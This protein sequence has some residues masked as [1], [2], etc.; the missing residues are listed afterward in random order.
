MASVECQEKAINNVSMG[1]PGR[2]ELR[3]RRDVAN[4][5]A[6]PPRI[7]E[8]VCGARK[9]SAVNANVGIWKEEQTDTDS[10]ILNIAI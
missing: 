3:I 7:I 1:K 10:A 8:F 5:P 4:R 9:R 2:T 6:K